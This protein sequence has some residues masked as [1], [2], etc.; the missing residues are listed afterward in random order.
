MKTL[1]LRLIVETEGYQLAPFAVGG[2]VLTVIILNVDR[3]AYGLDW[4]ADLL[5]S[6]AA[7]I[8]MW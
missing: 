8:D 7:L 1:M 6:V 4:F 5:R 2:G 3:L